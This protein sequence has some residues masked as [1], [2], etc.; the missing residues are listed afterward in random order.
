MIGIKVNNDNNY[1]YVT[2]NYR[3]IIENNW[4]DDLKYLCE[5]TEYHEKRI[6]VR[7]ITD[8]GVTREAN[9]HRVDSIAE[10]STRYCNYSKD[11]FN[12]EITYTQPCWIEDEEI[13]KVSPYRT[14]IIQQENGVIYEQETSEWSVIDWWLWSLACSEL[15]YMKLINLGWKAQQARKVL[16]LNTQSELI[17]TAFESD[18]KHFF[19][20]RTAPSAHPMMRDLVEPL[21]NKL[22]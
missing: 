14:D 8:I 21:K 12:G 10:S 2:L 13:E 15:A 16:P 7:F 11:K 6:C 3:H 17:H 1:V 5:P 18:W 9:R 22:F 20:L 4:L 19:E